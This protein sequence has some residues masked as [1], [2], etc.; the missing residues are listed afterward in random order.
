MDGNAGRCLA[1][2]L[3][4][5]YGIIDGAA[6]VAR[7]VPLFGAAEAL[8]LGGIRL[9]QFRWKETW[10]QNVYAETRQ[11]ADLC[12]ASGATFVINDR[13]DVAALLGAGI[14]VGQDDLPIT[15]VRRVASTAP[16]T[17]LSTHDEEQFGAGLEEN[18]DYLAFGP[19]FSTVSKDKPFPVTGIARLEALCKAS[20]MPVVAIGGITRERAPEIWNAGAASV[21]VIGDLYPADC[22][23]AKIRERAGEWTRIAE[24]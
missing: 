19:V 18:V 24:R 7:G 10:T 4:R 3:P 22:N 23:I 12:R 6:L 5:V 9:L 8:L 13:A 15:E 16:L 11:I 1:M 2:T 17:G 21:A 14:H 20:S